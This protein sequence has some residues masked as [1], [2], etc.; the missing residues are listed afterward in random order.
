MQQMWD[1]LTTVLEG[2][3]YFNMD[4][5]QVYGSSEMAPC[6]E[7]GDDIRSGFEWL[8]AVLG[9]MKDI[10]AITENG[11]VIRE[12]MNRVKMIMEVISVRQTS[13][14]KPDEVVLKS[15]YR[16][17]EM[18]KALPANSVGTAQTSAL[19]GFCS[20]CAQYTL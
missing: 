6:N 10:E 15:Y 17:Y 18:Q 2:H 5:R 1:S 11:A 14:S 4:V 3:G 7:Y 20:R 12:A 16:L 8:Y 9:F 19:M 13:S